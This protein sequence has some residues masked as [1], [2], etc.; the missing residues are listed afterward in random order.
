MANNVFA[1]WKGAL[2]TAAADVS[3]NSTAAATAPFVQL[4]DTNDVAYAPTHD[5]LSDVTAGQVGT[6]MQLTTPTVGTV[7]PGTFD[8]DNVTFA[9]VVGDQCEALVFYRNN[10]GAPGTKYLFLWLDASVT[11]LP[12]TPN[13]GNIT[14]TWSASGIFTL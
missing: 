9:A 7:S 1:V 11:G 5:F 2:M 6:A 10:A 4:H 14:I 12:V 3:L 8:A 13:G